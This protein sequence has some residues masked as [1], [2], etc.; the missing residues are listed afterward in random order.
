MMREDGLHI[1]PADLGTTVIDARVT[2][3]VENPPASNIREF[4]RPLPCG[5]LS[6]TPVPS[7]FNIWVNRNTD[8]AVLV[9]KG[10]IVFD[11]FPSGAGLQIGKP[12]TADKLDKVTYS[13]DAVIFM[14]DGAAADANNCITPGT[15]CAGHITLAASFQTANAA[16]PTAVNP[17]TYPPAA[18]T[19]N[20]IGFV[21]ERVGLAIQADGNSVS[22]A[23][24]LTLTA[25]FYGQS[26]L[27]SGKQNEIFGSL[28]SR[29]VDMG[30]QV[31]KIAAVKNMSRFL[32]PGLIGSAGSGS[33]Q[34]VVLRWREGTQ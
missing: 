30:S 9:V 1:S 6:A 22:G 16:Y 19:I 18:N 7:M 32:P 15:P 14:D 11:S 5:T 13:G 27:Y 26:E 24:Q 31:P 4:C 10:I 3:G 23:S 29:R 28:F 17:P 25:L 21:A 12:T 8:S 2:F 33:G 20:N 34:L